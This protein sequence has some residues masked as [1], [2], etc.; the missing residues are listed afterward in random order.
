MLQAGGQLG[1]ARLL[2]LLLGDG[3][4]PGLGPLCCLGT[5]GTPGLGPLCC[6]VRVWWGPP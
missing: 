5:A 4:T 3:C 6:L 1:V 2:L